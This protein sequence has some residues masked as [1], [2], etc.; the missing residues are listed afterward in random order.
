MLGCCKAAEKRMG[1]FNKGDYNVTKQAVS[2]K[3][4]ADLG[5]IPSISLTHEQNLKRWNDYEDKESTQLFIAQDERSANIIKN[6]KMKFMH[7][8]S[9]QEVPETMERRT[10]EANRIR[11][12]YPYTIQGVNDF[13]EMLGIETKVESLPLNKVELTTLK[14][15]PTAFALAEYLA[16]LKKNDDWAK[17]SD[18]IN[19]EY[20]SDGNNNDMVAEYY[21]KT[22]KA[23]LNSKDN[24]DRRTNIQPELKDSTQLNVDD[25]YSYEEVFD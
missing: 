18:I 8:L 16:V 23:Y 25:I 7:D 13:N 1:N 22:I 9:K 24:I 15:I 4:V 14:G 6:R 5:V 10:K 11:E 21:I 2:Q 19:V 3:L 12:A 20:S 17:I